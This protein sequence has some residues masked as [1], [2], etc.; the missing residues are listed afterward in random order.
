M[1]L[2]V[3]FVSQKLSCFPCWNKRVT[4]LSSVIITTSIPQN[5]ILWK[6]FKKCN[7][8]WLSVFVS[9]KDILPLTGP[10]NCP[11]A[12]VTMPHKYLII[13]L[14]S[15]LKL[16]LNFGKEKGNS[17]IQQALDCD[18][19]PTWRSYNYISKAS[20]SSANEALMK[21]YPWGWFNFSQ[22]QENFG[23]LLTQLTIHRYNLRSLISSVFYYIPIGKYHR[24]KTCY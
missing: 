22:R 21:T 13:I 2:V 4:L 19:F 5:I 12:W 9:I 16:F 7:C 15:N 8:I 20:L 10:K 14:L 24:I 23:S 6:T 18:V 3:S 1:P 11:H 17:K